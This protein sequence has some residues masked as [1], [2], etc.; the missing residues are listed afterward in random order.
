MDLALSL[1][2]ILAGSLGMLLLLLLWFGSS[3]I[4]PEFESSL[5]PILGMR[6]QMAIHDTQG[7]F[8]PMPEH[9]RTADE[10]VAWMTKEL[11]RL[12]A[13]IQKPH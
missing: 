11:P 10:M 3:T 5:H 12:T 2:A 8:I 4:E 9:L 7:P 13:D 6:D 1:L